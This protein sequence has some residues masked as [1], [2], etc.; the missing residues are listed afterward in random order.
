MS[1]CGQPLPPAPDAGGA[2]GERVAVH[3]AAQA[4]QIVTRLDQAVAARAEQ[5][6][7]V[8]RE[9]GAAPET[10]EAGEVQVRHLP[11]DSMLPAW[12]ASSSSSR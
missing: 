6:I 2:P 8:R 5:E 7:L 10:V 1:E 9:R 12:P 3:L 11:G 4:G